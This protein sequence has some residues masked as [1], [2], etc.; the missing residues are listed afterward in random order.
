V[1]IWAEG[2]LQAS[3]GLGRATVL[4]KVPRLGTPYDWREG[5][6]VFVK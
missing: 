5:D 6:V 4:A 3:S 1:S 2:A